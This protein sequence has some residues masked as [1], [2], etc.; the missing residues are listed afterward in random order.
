MSPYDMGKVVLNLQDNRI[1][2]ET[3]TMPFIHESLTTQYPRPYRYGFYSF[4]D[5]NRINGIFSAIYSQ[6]ILM[7]IMLLY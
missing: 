7:I 2:D 4:A 3:T 6:Y 5:K 1:F